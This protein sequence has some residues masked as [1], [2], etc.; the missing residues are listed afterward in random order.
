MPYRRGEKVKMAM[1]RHISQLSF[2]C[3]PAW[4][5]HQIEKDVLATK[6][7]RPFTWTWTRTGDI[8]RELS[9]VS[10]WHGIIGPHSVMKL[11][12][13]TLHDIYGKP[14]TSFSLFPGFPMPALRCFPSLRIGTIAMPIVPDFIQQF[15][16]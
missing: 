16:P 12:T 14:S 1:V 8:I 13:M 9:S 11:R 2:H 4:L 3:H 6:F 10:T 7:G 15:N 5:Y